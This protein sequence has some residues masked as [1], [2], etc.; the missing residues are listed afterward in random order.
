MS[1][2]QNPSHKRAEHKKDKDDDRD[3]DNQYPGGASSSKELP[4]AA[5]CRYCA[6]LGITGPNGEIITHGH[7]QC[8]NIPKWHARFNPSNRYGAGRMKKK[9]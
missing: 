6:D 8:K 5:A 1:Y 4:I 3:R 2:K 9:K 7:N